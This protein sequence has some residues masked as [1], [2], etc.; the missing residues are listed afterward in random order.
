MQQEVQLQYS[1]IWGERWGRE[2][3]RQ[4]KL[5]NCKLRFLVAKTEWELV[6]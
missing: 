6:D 2:T 5:N 4:L 1:Q 3:F